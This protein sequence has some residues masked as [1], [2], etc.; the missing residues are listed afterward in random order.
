[1]KPN[2]SFWVALLLV[3]C[4]GSNCYRNDSNSRRWLANNTAYKPVYA[5]NGDLNALIRNTPSKPIQSAGKLYLYKQYLL[6]AEPFLGVHI[7]DNSNP[8]SPVGLGFIEIPGAQDVL[9]REHYLYADYLGQMA[10]IDIENISAPRLVQKVKTQSL[11][12]TESPPVSANVGYTYF[13]CVD[14]SKGVVVGWMPV[15]YNKSMKCYK[16]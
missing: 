8:S 6:V 15:P 10:I 4:L 3:L 12:F 7:F 13:E 5:V 14:P 11:E 16:R 2:S 1:M 9:M